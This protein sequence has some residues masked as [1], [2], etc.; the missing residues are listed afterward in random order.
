MNRAS[1][2]TTTTTTTAAAAAHYS[3]NTCVDICNKI[4]ETIENIYVLHRIY[5]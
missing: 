3:K 5:K 2:T 1:T 4:N